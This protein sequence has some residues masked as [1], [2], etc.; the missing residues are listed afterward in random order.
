L[1]ADYADSHRL[2]GLLIGSY[3]KESARIGVICG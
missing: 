3:R 1:S 2:Y